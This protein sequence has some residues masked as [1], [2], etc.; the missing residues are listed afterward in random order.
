MVYIGVG[1][2]FSS[3]SSWISLMDGSLCCSICS[4]LLFTAAAFFLHLSNN[5]EV[6][7]SKLTDVDGPSHSV[8]LAVN[9]FTLI[10]SAL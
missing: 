8:Y 7:D 2:A 3:S 4:V 6:T 5:T 9:C 10:T 1:W